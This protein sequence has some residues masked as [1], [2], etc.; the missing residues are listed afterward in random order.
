MKPL[1]KKFKL[2]PENLSRVIED[3]GTLGGP[4]IPWNTG[5]VFAAGALGVSPI[6]FIPFVFLSYFTL[7]FTLIYGATGFTITKYDDNNIPKGYQN[8]ND[9]QPEMVN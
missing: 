8:N 1:Y 3:A 2:K 6:E 5:A 9:V 7:I 4:I